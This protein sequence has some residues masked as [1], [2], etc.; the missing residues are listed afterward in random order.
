MTNHRVPREGCT[1][2]ADVSVA[3]LRSFVAVAEELHFGRAAELLFMSAPALSQQIARL[4]RQLGTPLFLRT[5]RNVDLTA[6]GTELLPLART[7]LHAHQGI[8]S[9]IQRR[10]RRELRVGFT[11]VGPPTLLEPVFSRAVRLLG[12]FGLTFHSTRRDEVAPLLYSGALDA[13]FAWGPL[14]DA[15]I[16]TE[17]LCTSTRSLLVHTGHPQAQV[18]A[19]PL[20]QVQGPLVIPDTTDLAFVEWELTGCAV[21][22]ATQREGHRARSLDEAVAIVASGLAS[23]VVPTVVA[24]TVMHASICSIPI[25]DADP[26]TYLLCVAR[27]RHSDTLTSFLDLVPRNITQ[28]T[29]NS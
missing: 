27:G 13:V 29:L 11:Q 24:Q 7:A 17:T 26:Y 18:A 22:E 28:K 12:E 23:C 8:D 21:T 2:M 10:N 5:S 6:A 16:D 19:I 25:T 15:R 9:W 3:A 1:R 14:T 20:Q 4:E